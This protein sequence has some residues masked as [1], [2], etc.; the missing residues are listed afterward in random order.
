MGEKD[1]NNI[2]QLYVAI[3][4]GTA[5]HAITFCL[6]EVYKLGQRTGN[7]TNKKNYKWTK[8]ILLAGFVTLYDCIH[9]G[10]SDVYILFS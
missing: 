3:E 6:N 2:C 10:N 8:L 4:S 5:I 7:R 1:K 9:Y